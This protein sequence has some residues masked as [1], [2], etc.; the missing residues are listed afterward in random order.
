MRLFVHWTGICQLEHTHFILMMVI[1]HSLL[2]CRTRFL[3]LWITRNNIHILDRYM[4]VGMFL[5]FVMETRK[6]HGYNIEHRPQNYVAFVVLSCTKKKRPCYSWMRSTWQRG[7]VTRAGTV[8]HWAGKSWRQAGPGW[9]HSP[10][11]QE[12]NE[13]VFSHRR[14]N[15]PRWGFEPPTCGV[16]PVASHHSG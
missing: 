5:C 8:T 6:F 1:V 15:S 3:T 16:P 13:G 9:L 11:Y 2:S 10:S 4:G 14:G 12:H 7:T